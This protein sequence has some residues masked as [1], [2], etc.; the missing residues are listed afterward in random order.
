MFFFTTYKFEVLVL[1]VLHLDNRLSSFVF[2][3]NS[4]STNEFEVTT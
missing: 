4:F 1:G 3:T 2:G